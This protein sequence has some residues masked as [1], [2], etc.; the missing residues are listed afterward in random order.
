MIL[1]SITVCFRETEKEQRREQGFWD[2]KELEGGIRQCL[3]ALAL[4][5]TVCPSCQKNT[6]ATEELGANPIIILS[7]PIIPQLL[8]LPGLS[9][10]NLYLNPY[11]AFLILGLKVVP[12]TDCPV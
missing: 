7:S 4:S 9:I 10:P 12:V 11:C 5:S 2:V 3:Y 8:G 6:F 1:L